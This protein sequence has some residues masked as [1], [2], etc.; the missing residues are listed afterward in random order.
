MSQ[1]KLRRGFWILT[2]LVLGAAG[3]ACS[4]GGSG[5]GSSSKMKG[6]GYL[7]VDLP[8]LSGTSALTISGN[9]R[10]QMTF[11]SYSVGQYAVQL[12]QLVTDTNVAGD[13]VGIV[14]SIPFL[15][16]M[17]E[18]MGINQPGTYSGTLG[19]VSLSAQVTALSSDPDYDIEAV[20]TK[21][22]E[23]IFNYKANTAGTKGEIRYEILEF[24]E[25]LGVTPDPLDQQLRTNL[26]KWDSTVA[27]HG[28]VEASEEFHSN[29]QSGT[30]VTKIVRYMKAFVDEDRGIA[31]IVGKFSVKAWRSLLPEAQV[32]HFI[33]Q[34]RVVGNAVLE[35]YVECGEAQSTQNAVTLG[36]TCWDFSVNN[37]GRNDGSHYL[38]WRVHDYSTQ[39]MNAINGDFVGGTF[40]EDGITGGVG[41]TLTAPSPATLDGSRD[42]TLPGGGFGNTTL[43]AAIAAQRGGS[44]AMGF[45]ID[46][47]QS[48]QTGTSIA[49]LV[50]DVQA[51]SYAT[52]DALVAGQ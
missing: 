6:T 49:K 5:G 39:P 35:G 32:D 48:G 44:H 47:T 14:E 38:D 1:S 37:S 43:D 45:E 30:T 2:T 8:Q 22:G 25:I 23:E 31:D 13:C 50:Q 20:V 27:G 7:K 3:V 4:G 12:K 10:P 9:L 24:S 18:S 34:T 21:G 46:T 15:V 40:T 26:I 19:G 52:L 11:Q 16:C 28:V 42:W 41:L 51:V 36:T 29:Y 33:F 17:V